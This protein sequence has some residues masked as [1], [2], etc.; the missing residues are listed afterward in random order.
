LQSTRTK[1]PKL[2]LIDCGKPSLSSVCQHWATNEVTDE[3]TISAI[4]FTSC[5]G[6]DVFL[7]KMENLSP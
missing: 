7:A 2:G 3:L 4:A 6:A 1:L 5:A